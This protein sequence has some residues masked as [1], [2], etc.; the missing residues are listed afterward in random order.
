MHN[1][2]T[3]FLHNEWVQL[4]MATVVQVGVGRRFCKN[5]FKALRSGGSNM[6]VLEALGTTSAYLLS[7]YNGFFNPGVSMHGGMKELYFEFSATII[8]L[9]LLGK[10]MEHRAK[11]RTSDVSNSL[12]LKGYNP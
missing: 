1:P 2:V 11:G 5:A 10:Y 3:M 7:V 8:A 9:I 6:D 12:S 4:L